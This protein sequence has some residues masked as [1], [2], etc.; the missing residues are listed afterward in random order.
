MADCGRD[1]GKKG[2]FLGPSVGDSVHKH[3]LQMV[4]SMIFVGEAGSRKAGFPGEG[5]GV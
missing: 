2:G 5:V 3:I 1:F 4:D